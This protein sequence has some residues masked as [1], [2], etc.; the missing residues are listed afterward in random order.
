[1]VM[2]CLATG[3][4]YRREE[5]GATGKAGRERRLGATVAPIELTPERGALC[6]LTDI[7]EVTQLREQIALRKNL[8]S[9]GEM[10]R[11]RTRIQNALAGY[12]QRA[13][14]QTESGGHRDASGSTQPSRNGHGLSQ[15]RPP[16]NA[17]TFLVS[18]REII[19]DCAA[20]LQTLFDERRVTLSIEGEFPEARADATLLRQAI[21]NLLRNAAEAITEEEQIAASSFADHRTRTSTTSSTSQSKSKTRAAADPLNIERIFIPSS[22]PKRT[23]TASASPSPTASSQITAARSSP[24]TPPH[25]GAIFT[26]RSPL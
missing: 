20:E 17:R 3:E 19:E 9:L 12:A 1:M 6:L 10:S 7:T 18:T 25:S 16:A 21:L 26:I 4:V 24:P 14:T 23:A 15:F 22:P 2:R 5:V 11:T 13:R 8:A